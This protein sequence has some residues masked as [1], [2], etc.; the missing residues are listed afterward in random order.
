[1]ENVGD[2]SATFLPVLAGPS[3]CRNK[4]NKANPPI[5]IAWASPARNHFIPILPVS[6]NP[7]ETILPES[8]IPNVWLSSQDSLDDYVN[9]IMTPSGVRG[10]QLGGGIEFSDSYLNRLIISMRSGLEKNQNLYKNEK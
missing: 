3:E 6:N 5:A 10:I 8:L 7:G 4:H 9:Y 1:M 2:Y